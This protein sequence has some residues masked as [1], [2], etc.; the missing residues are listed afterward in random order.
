MNKISKFSED[1]RILKIQKHVKHILRIDVNDISTEF[2]EHASNYAYLCFLHEEAKADK[3]YIKLR[4]EIYSSDLEKDA[5]SSGVKVTDRAVEHIIARDRKWK[6][7]NKSYIK[8][9]Y[10]EGILKAS[11]DSYSQ[12]GQMLIS[13]GAHLRTEYDSDTKILKDKIKRKRNIN[14]EK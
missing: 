4:I 7:L 3:D 6:I 13:L 1:V 8:A 10:L 2:A 14:K 5:R 9:K 12:R 11:V